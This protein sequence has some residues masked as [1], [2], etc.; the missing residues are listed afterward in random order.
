[1]ELETMLRTLLLFS[2]V[3]A[4]VALTIYVRRLVDG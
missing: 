1:M 2:P 4:S 3:M